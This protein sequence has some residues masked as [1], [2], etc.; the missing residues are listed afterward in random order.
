VELE[1]QADELRARGYGIATISYDPPEVTAA[2]TEQNGISFTMLSDVGSETIRRFE[3]LNPVPEWAIGENSDDPDVAADVAT[4]VSVVNPSER[5]VGIAFPGTFMLD[6][7]G[8]VTSRYFE[9]S[10][11]ERNTVSS[12]IMRLGEAQAPVRAAQISK[13]RLPSVTGSH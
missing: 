11:I 2:F 3:L 9:D 4:F 6:T 5:M 8:R 13:R 12:I 7:D 1:S 10:Y